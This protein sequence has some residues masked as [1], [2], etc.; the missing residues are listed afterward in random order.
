M[1]EEELDSYLTLI[2]IMAGFPSLSTYITTKIIDMVLL[3]ID[4]NFVAD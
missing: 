1:S 2:Q 4:F 3:I